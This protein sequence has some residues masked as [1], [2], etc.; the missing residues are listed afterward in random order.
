MP[1]ASVYA[2]DFEATTSEPSNVYSFGIVNINKTKPEDVTVIYSKDDIPATIRLAVDKIF[3]LR[4]KSVIFFH[5]LTYDASFILSYILRECPDIVVTNSIIIGI[6]HN[7][8]RL[9]LKGRGKTITLRDS[10]CLFNAPLDDV[11]VAYTSFKKGVTPLYKT[12]EDIEFNDELDRYQRIDAIG[13]AEALRHRLE[14]G[15]GALTTAGGALKEFKKLNRDKCGDNYN[16]LF[17]LLDEEQHDEIKK[18]YRGGFSFVNPS[19]KGLIIEGVKVIDV[20]S[21]YPAQM[22]NKYL[23]SGF[24]QIVEGEV[25]PSKAYPLGIQK[26][27]IEWAELKDGYVPFLC[28]RAT[29]LTSTQYLDFID[30][31]FKEEDRTFSLTLQEFELFKKSYRYKG[32]NLL[33]G[34]LFTARKGLFDEY[35]HKFWS[36][37]CSNNKVIKALGKTFLNALYGKFGES[38]LKQNFN[39]FYDEK[40]SIELESEE[41]KPCG[42]MPVA[43][44]ITSYSRVFLIE[45]IL[46]IGY[47][48][49]LYCDTDSIHFTGDNVGNIHMHSTELGAWKLEKEFKRAK[50]IRAKR[51]IGEKEGGGLS[52]ACAGIKKSSI[53]RVIKKVEDFREGVGIETFEFKTGINGKYTRPKIVRI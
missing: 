32:L 41:V 48:N 18:A 39:L 11:L 12:I 40:L 13:L 43:V 4:D 28:K 6:T 17:P 38:Y 24:P 30:T 44:F 31:S 8:V 50:Y 51:Y 25:K 16:L 47:D 45:S 5:N 10:Y 1:R 27:S 22:K 34:Y 35:I 53:T 7:Y 26:F 15:C 23:P 36:M 46:S 19:Y 33:G 14:Y 2:A 49:F 21:M 29:S 37:K 52:I 20:N 3:S 9:T 42:Y